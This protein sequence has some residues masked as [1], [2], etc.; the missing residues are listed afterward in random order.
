M[1]VDWGPTEP[2]LA[3]AETLAGAWSAR[4]R[5]STTSGQERAL[6]RLFGV[7]GLDRSGRPLAG[8]VVDRYL[9]G[10]HG[11][12]A[13]GVV[14][15][16]AAGL[17]E[18]DLAPQA[19]A[20]DIAA[21]SIDL[22]LEAEL[23]RDSGR[24]A[25]AEAEA[26]RLAAAAIERIDANRTAR[27]ELLGLLGD[28]A[29][30]WIGLPLSETDLDAARPAI[31]RLVR[32]GADLVRVTVPVGR[33]LA[34]RLHDAGVDVPD[35]RTDEA[36]GHGAVTSDSTPAG[37]QRGLSE[38]RL[39]VDETAAERRSYVRLA[40]M[41]PGL[42]AP[43]QAIVAA[44]ERVDVVIADV[45]AEIVDGRVDPD[46]ALADHAFANRFHRRAGSVVPGPLVVAPD[47]ARG[48]PSDPGTRAGRG[49]AL[50]LLGVALARR[51]GVA[52]DLLVVGALP[53]WLIEERDGAARALAEVALR[54]ALLPDHAL[55]FE[56]P[57]VASGSAVAARW[58]YIVASA[59]PYAGAT[60]LVLRDGASAAATGGSAMRAAT[61]V[62]TEIARSTGP[63]SLQ[64]VA[65]DH[66][67]ATLT[68]AQATLDQLA[69]SGWRA[70]LGQ[71]IE[72]PPSDRLGAGAVVERTESFDPFAD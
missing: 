65:L 33:E 39:I 32:E 22:G 27:R 69:D 11:R 34:D 52:A 25:A 72:G 14:L 68:A 45:V 17:L 35:W 66:A 46:R 30:P 59:L 55:A 60:A 38:L 47:L 43:E 5:M 9:A 58:P 41:T 61:S 3:R 44:F 18:Y 20:L 57:P 1:A 62:G 53:A 49:L 31:R 42:A 40:T 15:P 50:Q 70:V 37:S 19:L 23:L 56:E 48:V 21:G 28:P 8:E 12:L 6:L 54:R 64:G 2:L 63:V 29:R 26:A 13:G 71:A 4:A 51:G 67:R 10:G 7:S 16:F 36:G 24:R